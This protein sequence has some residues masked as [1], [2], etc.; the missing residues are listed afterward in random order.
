MGLV[1]IVSALL[2]YGLGTRYIDD[3]L[4]VSLIVLILTVVLFIVSY[5]I[6]HSFEALAE[7]N[8]L[9]SEFVKIVSHQLRSPITNLKWAIEI[10]MAGGLGKIS[11]KQLEYFTILKENSDRMATLVK[12]LLTVSRLEEGTLITKKEKISLEPIIRAFIA[13]FEPFTSASN[14]K[15]VFE[16]GADIPEILIDAHQIEIVIENLLDNAVRYV[17]HTGEVRIK[18]EKKGS[19]LYFEIK[20][21][22]I[23]IPKEDQKF[24]FQKFFRSENAVKRQTQGSGLGLFI[25]R[26]IIEKY[27]GKIDFKSDEKDGSTFWFTLPII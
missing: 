26:S 11:G 5:G 13:R 1:I 6:T 25:A 10:L 17:T 23:G 12:D 4:V 9:K 8:R 14:A 18:L 3:P 24:I 22:G 20:D 7:A 16:T 19:N 27:G 15:I 21:T 2:A